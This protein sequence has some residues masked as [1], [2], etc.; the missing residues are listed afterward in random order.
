MSRIF[1]VCLA[2]VG[3]VM[4]SSCDTTIEIK[5][6]RVPQE[7]LQSAQKWA[8]TYE[9]YV[10]G[11]PITLSLSLNGDR[12]VIQALPDL[13]S[14]P[15]CQ[16]HAGW[17]R[18]ISYNKKLSVSELSFDFDPGFCTRELDGRSL[19]L[20]GFTEKDGA[21]S[22]VRYSIFIGMR[23]HLECRPAGGSPHHGGGQV[24]NWVERAYYLDSD[25]LRK[26]AD[27]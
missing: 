21:V 24:C 12:P 25:V 15:A 18:Q 17:L 3:L 14:D 27:R 11:Y 9:G 1:S 16:S 26:T 5:D 4:L 10:D 7:L 2:M 13:T 23:G 19:T 20:W 8:G 22:A 6:G